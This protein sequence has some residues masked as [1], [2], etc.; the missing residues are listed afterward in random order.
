[1]AS[2]PRIALIANPVSGR[3]RGA[4]V[5]QSL[6]AELLTRGV[7]ATAFTTRKAGD[8][9]LHAQQVEAD[10]VVAIGGDGTLSEVLDGAAG[11]PV[12][13]A[14][15]PL[16]T[17]NVL[18]LDMRL[19]RQVKRTADMLL[20]GR[21]VQ[22]DTALVRTHGQQERRGFLVLG[23]GFDGHAV[24][25]LERARTGPISKLTWVRAVLEAWRTWQ[26]TDLQVTVQGP[27]GSSQHAC[28]SVL[29]AN[30][31]HYGGFAVLDPDRRLDDGLYE[32][33]LF[34]RASRGALLRTGLTGAVGR[35]PGSVATLVRASQVQITASRPTPV[36]LD[37]D[38]LGLTPASLHVDQTRTRLVVP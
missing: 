4:Q 5:L 22:L 20:A 18:A 35:L 6:Q 34:A 9:R 3:G 37:G 36:Q 28:Q 8:A 17:A 1:M 32:V 27:H 19:P 30:C 15:V 12:C 23:V 26:P 38:A 13:V 24:H 16:G 29:V 21:T 25:T 14:Q 11:R 31:I 2:T 7:H 10:I 33:Y